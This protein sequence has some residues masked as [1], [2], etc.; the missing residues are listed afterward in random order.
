MAG[1]LSGVVRAAVRGWLD[2]G[3]EATAAIHA[4][5]ART[6][7]LSLP[8][9]ERHIVYLRFFE[10]L[11]QQEIADVVGMSQVHVSRL[12]RSALRSLKAFAEPTEADGTL[13]LR[14]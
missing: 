5:M 6:A 10:D 13:P 4:I 11:T 12:L 14:R 8:D 2:D 7:M 3:D 9:R 1:A